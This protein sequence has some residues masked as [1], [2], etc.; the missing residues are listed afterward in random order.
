MQA[1][2]TRTIKLWCW[3]FDVSREQFP[4]SIEDSQTVEDL[5]KV[6]LEKKRHRLPNFIIDEEDLIAWKVCGFSPF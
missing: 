4:V 5:K 2:P 6:I 1:N 3:I